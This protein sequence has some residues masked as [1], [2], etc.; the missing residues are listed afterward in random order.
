LVEALVVIT[1][2]AVLIW[3]RQAALV[4]VAIMLLAA[5]ALVDKVFLVGL[6]PSAVSNLVAE[7][8]VL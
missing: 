4:V 8:A 2:L 5:L 1:K 6:V 3:V 7:E